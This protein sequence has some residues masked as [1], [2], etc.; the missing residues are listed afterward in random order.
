MRGLIDKD[1]KSASEDEEDENDIS[2]PDPKKPKMSLDFYESDDEEEGEYEPP[3]QV[4]S[5]SF[6]SADDS[7]MITEE[8]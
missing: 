6:P 3:S 8:F 2:E 5:E 4:S 7:N 1:Q